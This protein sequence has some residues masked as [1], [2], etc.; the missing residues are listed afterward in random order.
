MKGHIKRFGTDYGGF[1]YPKD[2]PGL[3]ASSVIY[4]FGAGED[5]SHDV[6]LAHATGAPVHIFD[7]TPRAIRHI[8]LTQKVLESQTLISSNKRYGGG[9]MNYWPFI[10]EH[11]VP[12]TQ[13]VLHPYGLFTKDDPAMKFYLPSNEDY[14]SCSLLEGMKG[15]TYIEVPVKTLRTCMTELGHSQIDLLKMDIEG[16]ECDVLEAMLDDKI[17]PQYLSVDFDLGWTGEKIQDKPRCRAIMER[18][19]RSGYKLLHYKDANFSFQR[20]VALAPVATVTTP[21]AAVT[22]PASTATAA[23]TTG[24]GSAG[25]AS[26]M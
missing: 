6:A 15:T 4:C 11:S 1:Y 18:L 22:T 8:E 21:V 5:I 13:L 16:C 14:V 2:L 17:Y 25:L 10:L 24:A 3:S 26:A 9:D 19:L 12:K 20:A 7:P 23:A